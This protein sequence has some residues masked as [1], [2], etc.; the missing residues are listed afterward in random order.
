MSKQ[1]IFVLASIL[2][3][4]IFGRL[5]L[6][7][8]AGPPKGAECEGSACATAGPILA[9][10]MPSQVGLQRYGSPRT[11]NLRP[12]VIPR[13]SSVRAARGEDAADA[14]QASPCLKV[15][16][17]QSGGISFEDGLSIVRDSVS[18]FPN[19]FDG[20]GMPKRAAPHVQVC[21]RPRDTVVKYRC[22]VI[23][24]L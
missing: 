14:G 8:P 18:F 20:F 16:D 11:T 3:T 21:Q 1:Q 4:E 22:A 17:G 9:R 13:R 2:I 23:E 19:L 7:K 6:R 12:K 24:F 15:L 5:S 10:L